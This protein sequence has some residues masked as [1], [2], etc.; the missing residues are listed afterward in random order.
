MGP[1]SAVL[2]S[3]P[4]L[5][6]RARASLTL[7]SEENG[8]G[9]AMPSTRSGPRARQARCAVTAESIPPERPT[10][11]SGGSPCLRK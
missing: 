8:P 2:T 9:I 10:T 11:A 4:R 7:W 3:M 6:A 5:R 1:I